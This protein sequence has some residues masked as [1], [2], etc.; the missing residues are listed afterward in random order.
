MIA[1][2]RVKRVQ[3]TATTRARRTSTLVDLCAA[4]RKMPNM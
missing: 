2:E 4:E 1:D 3:I